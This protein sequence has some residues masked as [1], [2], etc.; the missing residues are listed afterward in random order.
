MTTETDEDLA[1]EY[2]GG[3]QVEKNGVRSFA[4][5]KPKSDRERE[6]LRAISRLLRG[7]RELSHA[8]RWRLASLFDPQPLS[9]ERQLTIRRRGRGGANE[10]S[11]LR[12]IEIGRSMAAMIDAGRNREEALDDAERRFGVSR[13]TAERA[14]REHGDVW[15]VKADVTELH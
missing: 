9:E 8:I 3:K 4:Y 5:V 2:L 13:S 14:F 15:R 10:P 1:L 11:A 6:C 7:D 12:A